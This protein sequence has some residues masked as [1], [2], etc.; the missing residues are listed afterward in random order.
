MGKGCDGG[1]GGRERRMVGEERVRRAGG[2]G[3]GR[4]RGGS[5]AVRQR[6]RGQDHWHEGMPAETSRHLSSRTCR[7]N[8]QYSEEAGWVSGRAGMPG[9][10]GRA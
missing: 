4:C 1:R 10:G 7:S 3:D 8:A 6:R 9:E 5:G 2:A